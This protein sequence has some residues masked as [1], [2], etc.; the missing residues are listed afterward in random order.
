MSD[1]VIKKN[2]LEICQALSQEKFME[3][4]YLA[5]GTALAIQGM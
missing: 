4:Y 2:I 1:I 5:G 3:E